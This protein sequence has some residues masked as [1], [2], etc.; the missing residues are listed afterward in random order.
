VAKDHVSGGKCLVAWDKI[1]KP[2]EFGG[3]G[4][5]NLH[6]QGLALRVRW[7][8]LRR[9]DLDRPWQGLPRWKDELARGVFDSL[10][11]IK[12]GKGDRVLF[13]TDRWMDGYCV[14]DL[15]PLVLNLV[16]TRRRNTRTV[17]EALHNDF[18]TTDIRGD[19]PPDGYLQYVQ[20][21]LIVLDLNQTRDPEGQDVFSWPCDASGIFSASSTYSRLCEGGIRFAAADGIWKPWAPSKCKIFTWLAVQYRVWTTERRARHGLQAVASACFTCLQDVD[22]LDHILL[23]C[24]YAKEVWFLSMSQANLP[25]VT[26]ANEDK[27]EE[28]WMRSRARVR[29]RERKTFDARVMLTCWSLWKQRNARAFANA[30][31]QCSAMELVRRIQEELAQW[32]VARFGPAVGG[33][34][35]LLGE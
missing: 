1:C 11:K 29:S 10:V 14:K 18:W 16:N 4:V 7:E 21:C 28:W 23:H 6:L 15:A 19:L 33:S 26:P 5:K 9:T 2:Y 12:V 27:L 31:L 8:W 22:S 35:T 25:D 17:Q 3:L 30:T 13:W 20:L 24:S 34:Y 32:A